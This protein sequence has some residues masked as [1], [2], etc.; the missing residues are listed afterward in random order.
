MNLAYINTSD[1][2]IPGDVHISGVHKDYS[3]VD[4]SL[5]YDELQYLHDVLVAHTP[6]LHDTEAM[7]MKYYCL[8][9]VKECIQKVDLAWEAKHASN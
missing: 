9:T 3:Q 6:G 5:F 2:V 4:T 7:K 8:M 1:M